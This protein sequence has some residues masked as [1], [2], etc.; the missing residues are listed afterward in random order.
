MN[1]WKAFAE[2]RDAGPERF[3]AFLDEFDWN[4]L[5][6]H[7]LGPLLAS[8]L[9]QPGVPEAVR[10]CVQTLRERGWP[11]DEELADQLDAVLGDGERPDLIDLP[12]ELDLLVGA[13]EGDPVH[14]GGAID[15]RTGNLYSQDEIDQFAWTDPEDLPAWAEPIDIEE[16]PDD[17]LA[18]DSRGS[19]DGY[20][21]MEYFIATV[22]GEKLAERLSRA[23][24]GRGAFRRF[25]DVVFD[26]PEE[27]RW[28]AVSSDRRLGR[29]RE[30]LALEG[31]C[32]VPN[33]PT[34][35]AG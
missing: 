2:A 18:F 7:E 12:I 1:P 3:A 26:T 27:A 15:L 20:R 24:S 14:R 23:I 11:G 34:P 4:L 25:R 22:E 33:R 35:D 29:A 16:N 19:R 30:W 21:D 32:P 8:E 9:E 31:Y 13:L 5:A 28:N 6:L 10:R 17:W